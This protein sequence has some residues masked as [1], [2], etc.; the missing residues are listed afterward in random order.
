M[1]ICQRS[2]WRAGKKSKGA[3]RTEKKKINS[4]LFL[5]YWGGFL[6]LARFSGAPV[7]VFLE[8]KKL[9]SA[10]YRQRKVWDIIDSGASESSILTLQITAA[11]RDCGKD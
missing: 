3:R 7:R 1:S 11:F 4:L 8:R 10:Q 2:L 5:Y 6:F 9:S